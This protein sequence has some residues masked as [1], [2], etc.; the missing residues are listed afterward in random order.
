MLDDQTV[1]IRGPEAI[2]HYCDGDTRAN[3]SFFATI[4]AEGTKLSLILI[5]KRK[6]RF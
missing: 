1:A 4:T 2:C 6:V 5:T 3:F